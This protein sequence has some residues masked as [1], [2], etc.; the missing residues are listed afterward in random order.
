MLGVLFFLPMGMNFS[1]LGVNKTTWLVAV[2]MF[3][4]LTNSFTTT[5]GK[6]IGICCDI[7]YT[8]GVGKM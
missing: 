3:I 6:I 1:T 2:H 7:A 5:F 8:I 4:W